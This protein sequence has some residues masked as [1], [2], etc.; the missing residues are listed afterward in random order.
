[1]IPTD[2]SGLQWWFKADAIGGL[3]DD[4]PVGTW[5]DS[6]GGGFDTTQGTAGSKPLYKTN[7]LNG[8]P[9]V[10]GDG[11]DD[12]LSNTAYSHAA[13]SL[14]IFAVLRNNRTSAYN[15]GR[16][17]THGTLRIWIEGDSA[18]FGPGW[19]DGGA[20]GGWFGTV[21]NDWHIL[22]WDLEEGSNGSVFDRDELLGLAAYTAPALDDINLFAESGG[23]NS[24]QMDL[25][26]VFAFDE[27]LSEG[28]HDGM[29]A[30]LIGKYFPM[31]ARMD[32]ASSG[33]VQHVTG[34]D[35]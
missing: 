29:L 1:M 35:R 26:E 20:G 15:R 24:A 18:A 4:D 2:V 3:S 13:T 19:F 25:C 21:D 6:G 5:A 28:D 22:V 14:T 30:Y 23:S 16:L 7:Q 17:S 34:V 32:Y 33:I 12:V 9:S 11:S 31:F 10:R 27:I 8:K